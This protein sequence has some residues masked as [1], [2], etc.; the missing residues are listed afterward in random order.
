VTGPTVLEVLDGALASVQ[1]AGRPKWA[2]LGVPPGG[3]CDP[4]GFAVANALLDNPEGAAA[5]EI[6]LGG[7]AFA[8]REST[9]V[10]IGGA[11]L[12]AVVVEE[13]RELAA[14]ASHLIQAGRTVRFGGRPPGAGRGARAYLAVPGGFDVPHVMGSAATSL[15]GGFG[16]VDGRGL[17][18]GDILR[19]AGQADPTL[20]G[21][22]WPDEPPGRAT[23]ATTQGVVRVVA[24]PH[25]DRFLGDALATF[26]DSEWTIRH[27]S[28]RMGIRLAGP[29]VRLRRTREI[30]SLPM[31][32]GAIQV[33]PDG[34]PIALLAD[35]QT[36][37]GYPVLAVV[38]RADRPV[39]GQL[40]PG[41]RV[42]FE[43]VDI[44]EAQEAWREDRAFFHTALAH[45]AAMERWND[46]WL[47]AGS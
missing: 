11:E 3:A 36:V 40:A 9:V 14:D 4:H 37:G 30:V 25:S 8:L 41:D 24:G 23:W 38:I 16:G 29:Q 17:R 33:P 13:D 12:G 27:E 26:L 1:D 32:W 44:A 34:M 15:I 5:L 39:V 35:H 19:G 31:I 47:W 45:L 22:R 43:L 42:R 6:A 7:F 46:Q 20:A 28:D 2:R 10:A 21:R 18:V